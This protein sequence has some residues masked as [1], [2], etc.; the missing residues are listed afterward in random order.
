MTDEVISV[1]ANEEQGPAWTAAAEACSMTRHAWIKAMLEIACGRSSIADFA[2]RMKAARKV[3]DE[4]Q[5]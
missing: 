3:A 4:N 5:R 2:R 1:K